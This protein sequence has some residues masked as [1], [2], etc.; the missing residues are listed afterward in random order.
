M[1]LPP[2]FLTRGYPGVPP[3]SRLDGV[4]PQT[5]LDGGT[6]HPPISADRAATWQAVCLMRSHRKTFLFAYV[7][8]FPFCSKENY[9][10]KAMNL[11]YEFI[12]LLLLLSVIKLSH[13]PFE[14]SLVAVRLYYAYRCNKNI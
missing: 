11:F 9:F 4:P 12:L 7:I 2:F 6:L 3:W 10:C 5:G 8:L 14:K 1:G 13:D